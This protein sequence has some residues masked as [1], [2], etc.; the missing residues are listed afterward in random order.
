MKTTVSQSVK[1]KWLKRSAEIQN[2]EYNEAI[3]ANK[4]E[5]I[6]VK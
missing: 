2:I 1:E 5:Y 3:E 6:L 4:P